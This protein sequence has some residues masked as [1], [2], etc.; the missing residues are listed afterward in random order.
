MRT[1]PARV[2]GPRDVLLQFQEAAQRGRLLLEQHQLLAVALLPIFPLAIERFVA[3]HELRDPRGVLLHD[4]LLQVLHG[5]RVALQR[6]DQQQRGQARAA[7]LA[8]RLVRV[9]Q[10]RQG[11]LTPPRR[12]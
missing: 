8:D 4:R 10:G 3:L 12:G 11:S 1:A 7:D 9:T 2:R 5:A 6:A